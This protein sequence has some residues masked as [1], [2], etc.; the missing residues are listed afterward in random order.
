MKKNG[1][2]I[3]YVLIIISIVLG[4]SMA[5]SKIVFSERSLTRIARD[6]LSARSAADVGM[7]CMMNKD[8]LP[9]QF[10][11]TIY[12]PPPVPPA[13]PMPSFT[14][15]CGR[16]NMGSPILYEAI[17]D[18]GVASPNYAYTVAVPAGSPPDG[19]CFSAYLYRQVSTP[20]VSTKLDVYGYNICDPTN[21]AHVQ[22]GILAEY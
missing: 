5:V 16:D 19:P 2:A 11:P 21:P 8:K 1:F 12:P 13:P 18:L 10:D 20:P 22:R 6:S 4:L 15:N 7:E 14:F 9:T 17:Q 3:L